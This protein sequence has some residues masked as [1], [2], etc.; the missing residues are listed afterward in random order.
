MKRNVELESKESCVT[1]EKEA[2]FSTG[3]A[4]IRHKKRVV[5]RIIGMSLYKIK[6]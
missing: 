2:H 5:E 3:T 4:M 6:T 1:G